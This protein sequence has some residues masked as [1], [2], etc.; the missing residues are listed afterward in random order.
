[1]YKFQR[2]G[3]CEQSL[4]QKYCL[5]KFFLTAF[6]LSCTHEYFKNYSMDITHMRYTIVCV[7]TFK[8]S[9]KISALLLN[10]CF[11]AITSLS[12]K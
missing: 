9:L 11:V 3:Q 1:M 6:S 7:L 4:F 5:W 2:H 12:I 8:K 10:I